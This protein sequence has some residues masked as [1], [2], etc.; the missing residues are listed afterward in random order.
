MKIVKQRDKSPLRQLRIKDE[1]IS[2]I[3]IDMKAPSKEEDKN[4][5]KKEALE[6][7]SLMFMSKNKLIYLSDPI[8]EIIKDIF[9][10]EVEKIINRYETKANFFKRRISELYDTIKLEVINYQGDIILH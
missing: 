7:L 6:R 1:N 2:Q 3:V 9:I 4:K 10:K 8:K 5:L